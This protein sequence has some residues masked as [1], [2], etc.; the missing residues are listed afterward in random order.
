MQSERR[1]WPA[2]SLDE[3]YRILTAPGSPFEMETV[4]VGGATRPGLQESP[5]RSSRDFRGQQG[6]GRPNLPRVRR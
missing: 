1:N 4:D 2:V 3:T 6:V 5:S